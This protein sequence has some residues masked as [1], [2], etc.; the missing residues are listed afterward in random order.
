MPGAPDADLLVLRPSF[1]FTYLH[2]SS[3]LLTVKD[4]RRGGC[5]NVVVPWEVLGRCAGV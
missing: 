2:V 4:F 1:G 3:R 5:V